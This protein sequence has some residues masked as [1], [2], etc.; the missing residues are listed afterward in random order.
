MPICLGNN[1]NVTFSGDENGNIY[2][3]KDFESIREDVGVNLTGHS[4]PISRISLTPDDKRLFS[5]GVND[6]CLFQ[7][8]VGTVE[9]RPTPNSAV[10]IVK[11]QAEPE[12]D[13][14][15]KI[16]VSDESLVNEIN[17][18]FVQTQQENTEQE[19]QPIAETGTDNGVLIR[20][21]NNSVMNRLQAK[22]NFD[23]QE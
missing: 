18:C 12:T 8:K 14:Q 7:W 10:N 6:R 23:N 17:Y 22:L 16:F 1:T 3:W 2:L 5:I 9:Q 19:P 15:D 4:A 11:A 21:C 13:I 20:G